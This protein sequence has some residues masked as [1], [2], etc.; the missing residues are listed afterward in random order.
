M[1]DGIIKVQEAKVI[2]SQTLRA[3]ESPGSLFVK[4]LIARLYPQSF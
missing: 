1:K 4:T 2:G 3:L